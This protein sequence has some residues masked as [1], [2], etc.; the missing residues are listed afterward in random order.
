MAEA[1]ALTDEQVAEFKEAFALELGTVMRSLGQNPTE[2]ELQDMISEVDADGNGTIDFPEFLG[3]M[4]RKMKDTDSEEELRE[5]FKVFDKDGNGFISA[6]EL[7]HVMTN[8]GEK[9][10]DEEVDEMIR[11]ADVDGDGQEDQQQQAVG[12]VAGI[13]S[14]PAQEQQQDGDVEVSAPAAVELAGQPEEEQPEEEEQQAGLPPGLDDHVPGLEPDAAM[15]TKPAPQAE[16]P[17]AQAPVGAGTTSPAPAAYHGGGV[18]HHDLE[19]PLSLPPHGTEIFI[20]GL[21]RAVTDGELHDFAAQAGEVFSAQLIKDPQNPANNRGYGFVKYKTKEGALT[22]LDRLHSKELS[23]YHGHR[24]R[25]QQSQAKHKLFMGGIPR[26]MTK[27][28]L[29][30]AIN[31]VVKGLQ[32]VDLVMSKEQPELNRGFAFVEFYNAA[33]AQLA[34]NALSSPDF[35]LG[36]RQIS[37]DFAEPTQKEQQ[38]AATRTVWVGNLPEGTTDDRLREAF[39]RFGEVDRVNI[40][41]PREGEAYSRF[42]FVNFVERVGAMKAVEDPARPAIDGVELLVHYGRTSEPRGDTQGGGGYGGG[43]YGGGQ[44]GG[45]GGGRGRGGYSRGGGYGGGGRGGRGGGRGGGYARDSYAE[46]AYDGGYGAPAPAY[47]VS[48]QAPAVAALPAVPAGAVMMGAPGAQVQTLIPVQLP[49]GQIGYMLQN[50]PVAAGAT[51]APVVAAPAGYADPNQGAPAG[52]Y[53]GVNDG[54]GY[55]SSGGGYGRDRGGYR[56]GRGGGRGGR[57]GG[58][59]YAPY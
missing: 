17:K 30:N 15:D 8:L 36:D 4:A 56:G 33:C 5:A 49:N 20:G 42:G 37:V 26:E 51:P 6:A 55:G 21:P 9:L 58:Q 23:G 32:H 13:E 3:L 12:E 18:Y 53:G 44:E 2:A 11:E 35:K 40:P 50:A 29:E 24:V 41:R 22:A 14:E 47:E 39:E 45:Y 27:A 59:R 57:G 54:Y 28:D 19:D 10:T 25:V 1:A 31:A 43:G 48:P 7:R 46:P 16:T 38:S 34:K 52:S